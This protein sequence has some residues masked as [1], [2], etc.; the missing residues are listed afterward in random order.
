[1]SW[2]EKWTKRMMLSV[3]ILGVVIIYSGFIYLL[4]SGRSVAVLP[5]YLLLSPWICIFFGLD[6]A[7]QFRVITWFVRRF[8]H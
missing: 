1:M 7:R 2:L 8:K 5:W 4:L 3:G 6:H